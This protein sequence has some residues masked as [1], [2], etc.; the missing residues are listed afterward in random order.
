MSSTAMAVWSMPRKRR[1]VGRCQRGIA[2]PGREF[3][4]LQGMA[5]GVLEVEGPDAAGDGVPGRQG[6]RGRGRRGSTRCWREPGDRRRSIPLA[7]SATC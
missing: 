3:E 5:V 7:I 2:L 1:S 4:D 6:L